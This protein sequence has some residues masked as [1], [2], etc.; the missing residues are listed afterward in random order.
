VSWCCAHFCSRIPTGYGT[1]IISSHSVH[2]GGKL[3]SITKAPKLGTILHHDHEILSALPCNALKCMLSR[4]PRRVRPFHP[5]SSSCVLTISTYHFPVSIKYGCHVPFRYQRLGI[6][7]LQLFP[8]FLRR[9]YHKKWMSF[10]CCDEAEQGGSPH[11][12]ATPQRGASQCDKNA[13]V[14]PMHRI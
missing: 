14:K 5:S 3:S 2:I 9:A 8:V 7:S 6:V 11:S 10:F 4:T 13:E 12:S 1:R